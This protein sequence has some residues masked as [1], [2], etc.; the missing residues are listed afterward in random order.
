MNAQVDLA[1][2]RG[3]EHVADRQEAHLGQVN[4]LERTHLPI[5]QRLPSLLRA[6][7]ERAET[8]KAKPIMRS[9]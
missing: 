3:E 8:E 5:P 6:V 4:R 1:G 7:R 9:D 2:L